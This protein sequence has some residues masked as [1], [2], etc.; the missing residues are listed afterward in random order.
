MRLSL[1]SLA[2]FVAAS[3]L[4]AAYQDWFVDNTWT[5]ATLGTMAAPFTDIQSAVD[6]AVATNGVFNGDTINVVAS[7][8]DYYGPVVFPNINAMRLKGTNGYPVITITGQVAASTISSGDNYFN[9][10][11]ACFPPSQVGL[12]Q[13][14]IRNQSIATGAWYCADV[15]AWVSW[16]AGLTNS[17]GERLTERERYGIVDCYFDGG[18]THGGL[19][20]RDLDQRHRADLD[21][22]HTSLVSQCTFENCSVAVELSSQVKARVYDNWFFSN[23][24]ALAATEGT[25]S[26]Y[27]RAYSNIVF[28]FNVVTWCSGDAFNS[29]I[30]PLLLIYNNSFY[31]GAGTACVLNATSFGYGGVAQL[32]N[33]IFYENGAA[34]LAAAGDTNALIVSNNLYYANT[35]AT[36][37]EMFGGGAVTLD[38]AFASLDSGN[39]DFLRPLEFS[40]AANLSGLFGG[41][42]Y[43]GA[44]APIPEPVGVLCVAALLALRRHT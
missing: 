20:L 5:G 8:Q 21:S 36:G 26:I 6:F 40:P 37:W 16:E 29:D 32:Q 31:A 42:D 7:G 11:F 33:N 30:Y 19:R 4:S 1:L 25:N 2:C 17:S 44:R 12:E 22:V 43:L 41:V 14:V 3:T 24:W 27:Q 10:S 13:L 9:P 35:G 18:G 23:A 38:P 39:A 28:C 34:W 15:Q